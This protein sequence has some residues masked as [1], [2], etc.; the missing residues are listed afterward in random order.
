M[1]GA[2]GEGLEQHQRRILR[3]PLLLM[4]ERMGNASIPISTVEPPRLEGWLVRVNAYFVVSFSLSLVSV[5]LA[6]LAKQCESIC[7][8]FSI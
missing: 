1:R 7:F 3:N 5:L 8:L 4:Y 2:V 6:M